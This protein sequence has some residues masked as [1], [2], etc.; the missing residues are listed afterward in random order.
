VWA[1]SPKREGGL[2]RNRG[3]LSP[4]IR[5]RIR[6]K[7]ALTQYKTLFSELLHRDKNDFQLIVSILLMQKRKHQ[8]PEAKRGFDHVIDRVSEPV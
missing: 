1:K 2:D 5:G 4:E 6:P 3:A 8:D 7:Y